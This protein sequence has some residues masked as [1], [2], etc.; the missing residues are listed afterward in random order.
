[1]A[2]FHSR[3]SGS[4]P[5]LS[6]IS[7]ARFPTREGY[8]EVTSP[9][10]A[11]AARVDGAEKNKVRGMV[12]G[13]ALLMLIQAAAT[14]ALEGYVFGRYTHNLQ[15]TMDSNRDKLLESEEDPYYIRYSKTIPT[16]LSLLIFGF[17]YDLVLV[18]DA[19]YHKNSIQLIGLCLCN[20]GLMI[21]GAVQIQQID[22]AVSALVSEHEMKATTWPQIKG[23]LIAIPVVIG[24]FTLVEACLTWSLKQK[25][26]WQLVDATKGSLMKRRG[27]TTY[28]LYVAMLKFDIFFFLGFT[29]QFVVIV[30]EDHNAEFAVTV[31]AIPIT[32][33]IIAA[34][35]WATIK[36][37]R[38]VMIASILCFLGGLAYFI[39]KMVRMYYGP[40]KHDYDAARVSLTFFASITILLILT[41]IA[42]AI[43]CYRRFGQ[44]LKDIL[45]WLGPKMQDEA[46]G[47]TELGMSGMPNVRP[48]F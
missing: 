4:T 16:F 2:P 43:M 28:Q 41:T 25:F 27:L 7:I 5:S 37:N 24:A 30:Q 10:N 6:R 8:K 15:P 35:M 46:Q 13:Y 33:L 36:E 48:A 38:L 26:G 3:K 45:G 20:I 9:P 31:A 18:V 11:L 1:M 32:I 42:N 21:Y 14:L 39:F 47:H 23:C 29:I 40:K 12:I 22:A 19:L 34:A 17:I 44:G